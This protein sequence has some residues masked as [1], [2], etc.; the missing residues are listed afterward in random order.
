METQE[1]W[2]LLDGVLDAVLYAT[3]KHAGQTRRGSGEPYVVHPIRVVRHLVSVRVFD[4]EILQ[5]AALHD[6]L[7][8]CGVEP[9]AFEAQ[10]GPKVSALV[11]ELTNKPGL[12]REE[13]KAYMVEKF[14]R[15]SIEAKL[16]KLADRLDNLADLKPDDAWSARYADETRAM[17]EPGLT[18]MYD[19]NYTDAHRSLTRLIFGRMHKVE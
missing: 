3:V 1:V 18:S 11:T 12:K 17:L 2:E 10:W 19:D 7:E 15:L 13:K 5:A 8:D 14:K 4:P 6:V 9:A 16:I